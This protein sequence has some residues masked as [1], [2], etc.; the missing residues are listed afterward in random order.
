MNV[1]TKISEDVEKQCF[2]C[3][4]AGKYKAQHLH[5]QLLSANEF[6]HKVWLQANLNTDNDLYNINMKKKLQ[7][8][9]T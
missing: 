7:G 4:D 9:Q 6:N 3:D 5:M 8:K 1:L 2:V